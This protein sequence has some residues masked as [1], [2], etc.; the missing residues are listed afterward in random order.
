ML[1]L[2]WNILIPGGLAQRRKKKILLSQV[3]DDAL[4]TCLLEPRPHG[5]RLISEDRFRKVVACAQTKLPEDDSLFS[6]AEIVKEIRERGYE[7]KP[8][9]RKN[10]KTKIP[11]TLVLGV[12]AALLLMRGKEKKT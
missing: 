2:I 4:K 8:Q 5:E 9:K 6:P 1:S 12:I 7:P 10:Q 3:V 11:S